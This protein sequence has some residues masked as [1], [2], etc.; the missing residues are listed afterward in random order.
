MRQL[1]THLSKL[2]HRKDHVL[3]ILSLFFIKVEVLII[4]LRVHH[5]FVQHSVRNSDR[6]NRDNKKSNI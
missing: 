5:N 4:S 2:Y 3:L 6:M 1:F